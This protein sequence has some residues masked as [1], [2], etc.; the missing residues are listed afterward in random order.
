[1][2]RA[3]T[4]GCVSGGPENFFKCGGQG[5]NQNNNLRGRGRRKTKCSGTDGLKVASLHQVQV[6][7][8]LIEERVNTL[9]QNEWQGWDM[10]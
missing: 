3:I 7:T 6:A 10:V 5:I 8:S 4:Q 9:N 2:F 1:M